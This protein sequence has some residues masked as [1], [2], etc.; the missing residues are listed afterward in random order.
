VGARYRTLTAALRT[1]VEEKLPEPLRRYEEVSQIRLAASL[2]DPVEFA[3]QVHT[4]LELILVAPLRR[5]FATLPRDWQQTGAGRAAP[6]LF[7]LEDE[8]AVFVAGAM[9]E[10]SETDGPIWED[11]ETLIWIVESRP[12]DARR[13]LQAM[14]QR[15]ATEP[16]SPLEAQMHSHLVQ[17]VSTW[18]SANS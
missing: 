8:V 11:L 2:E 10:L 9:S 12:A 17:L 18:P 13:T 5:Q 4:A 1:V 15:Y 14:S 6:N 7:L 3:H 16:H